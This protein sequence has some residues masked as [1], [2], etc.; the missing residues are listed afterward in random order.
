MVVEEN[1]II[2]GSLEIGNLPDI[3][4][5]DLQIRVDTGAKTSSLHVDNITK[6]KRD[7]KPWVKFDLH[8]DVYNVDDVI[9]CESKLHDF[10]SVKSSNGVSQERYVIKTT[11]ELGADAWPI[12][13]TLTNRS[14][15]TNLMLLGREGMKNKILVDPSKT[16]VLRSK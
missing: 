14:D 5:H 3:G 7:G 16:F 11:F 15:M 4:I 1:K 9:S 12:E 6:F 8:P 10:R 2:V 13:I